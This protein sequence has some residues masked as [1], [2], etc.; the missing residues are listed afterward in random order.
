V[1][2]ALGAGAALGVLSRLGDHLLPEP[3]TWFVDLGGPWLAVA[4]AVGAAVRSVRW[5]ALA[6]VLALLAAVASYYGAT[7]LVDEPLTGGRTIPNPNLVAPWV[8]LALIGGPLF[9]LAGA[10]W[11]EGRGRWRVLAVAL[12]S[13]ALAGEGAALL[14][15][16]YGAADAGVLAT[17]PVIAA[18]LPWLLLR[19][20]QRAAALAL[21]G[22]FALLALAAMAT[23][24]AVFRVLLGP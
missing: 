22:G 2:L 6:G 7:Y 24:F 23:L 17:E 13:G 4:F 8:V 10:A 9:G 16:G 21:T 11:R 14:L 1:A 20:R 12:L 18:L 5:G 15:R 3:Y 19:G